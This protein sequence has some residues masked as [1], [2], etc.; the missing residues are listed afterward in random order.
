[1]GRA[2]AAATSSWCLCAGHNQISTLLLSF[3]QLLQQK[4][5]CHYSVK[6][7]DGCP[8][9]LS[10]DFSETLRTPSLPDE[11]VISR[12]YDDICKKFVPLKESITMVLVWIPKFHWRVEI[13]NSN[14]RAI[15]N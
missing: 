3:Q 7:K 6:G 10:L 2:A 13:R 12:N 14:I 15:H 9:V 11:C 1:M 5:I 4:W 8:V